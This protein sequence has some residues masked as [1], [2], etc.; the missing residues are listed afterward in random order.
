MMT[1]SVHTVNCYS[2]RS[3]HAQLLQTFGAHVW[4]QCG[5]SIDLLARQPA[6]PTE[7][8]HPGCTHGRTVGVMLVRADGESD[9]K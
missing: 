3:S 9:L 5:A 4:A 1:E 7:H 8:A 6:R 2:V